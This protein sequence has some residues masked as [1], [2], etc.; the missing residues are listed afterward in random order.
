MFTSHDL[1]SHDV[2][3]YYFVKRAPATTMNNNILLSFDM[4]LVSSQT[5]PCSQAK[6]DI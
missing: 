4:A 5:T 1:W 3:L 6:H 2:C